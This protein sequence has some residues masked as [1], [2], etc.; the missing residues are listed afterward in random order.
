MEH[1]SL[2]GA[3]CFASLRRGLQLEERS[4]FSES[5]TRAHHRNKGHLLVELL[6]EADEESIDECAIF[7]RVAELT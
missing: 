4:D 7:N 3:R 1:L 6:A 2:S 5:G